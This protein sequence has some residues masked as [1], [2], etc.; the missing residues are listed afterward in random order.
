[1]NQVVYGTKTNGLGAQLSAVGMHEKGDLKHRWVG[2]SYQIRRQLRLESGKFVAF[3]CQFTV[4]RSERFNREERT[5]V[6]SFL[7]TGHLSEQQREVANAWLKSMQRRY[8]G[9]PF[10]HPS[11]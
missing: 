9:L 7:T 1:M 8:P 3:F 6:H 4:P 11:K 10:G 2:P 5:C